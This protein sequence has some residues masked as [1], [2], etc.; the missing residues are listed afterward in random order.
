MNQ[1][2]TP[3]CENQPKTTELTWRQ[4]N[5]ERAQALGRAWRK[6]NRDKDHEHCRRYARTHRADVTARV[7][8]WQLKQPREAFLALQRRY[9]ANG[10][11]RRIPGRPA[12]KVT[13]SLP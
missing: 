10:R 1:P 2:P 11:A 4:R 8:R 9:K 6:S 7:R 12:G 13:A 5:P 3:N